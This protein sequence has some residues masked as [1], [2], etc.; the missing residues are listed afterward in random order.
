[1]AVPSGVRQ[2]IKRFGPAIDRTV[3]AFGKPD[4]KNILGCGSY[5]CVAPLGKNRIVKVR[6]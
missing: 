6:S 3:R 2:A 4:W 1:M 5:G